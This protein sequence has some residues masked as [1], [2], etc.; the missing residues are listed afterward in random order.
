MRNASVSFFV[1][2]ETVDVPEERVAEFY[3]RYARFLA[4]SGT[5]TRNAAARLD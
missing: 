2:A 5:A 3:A 1:E 4:S